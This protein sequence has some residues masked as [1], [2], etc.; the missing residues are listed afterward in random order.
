MFSQQLTQLD[1]TSNILSG[2]SFT[3]RYQTCCQDLHAFFSLSERLLF[4]ANSGI[5]QL[6]HDENKLIFNELMMR[7]SLY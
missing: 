5:F 6:Y 3:G 4:H 1:L 2:F 7:S